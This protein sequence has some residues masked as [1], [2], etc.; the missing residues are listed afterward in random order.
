[1]A[2]VSVTLVPVAKL[3][4]ASF[5]DMELSIF[6]ILNDTTI[7]KHLLYSMSASVF[8]NDPLY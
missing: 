6:D 5:G 8:T 3:R 7:V 2:D 1:M 4:R